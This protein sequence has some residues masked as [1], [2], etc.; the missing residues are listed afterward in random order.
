[1]IASEWNALQSPNNKVLGYNGVLNRDDEIG[2]PSPSAIGDMAAWYDATD[3]GSMVIDASAN[4]SLLSDVSGQSTENCL[5]LSGVIGN[6]A[7][8][9]DSAAL[10][11]TTSIDF[12]IRFAAVDWTPS[13]INLLLGKEK[14]GSK[15]SFVFYL[16]TTGSL[17]LGLSDDGTTTLPAVNSDDPVGFSDYNAGWL[18]VTWRASD[19][20][21]QF[22]TSDDSTSIPS[23]WT[24]LGA[25]KTI[26]IA[27]IYNSV[28]AVEIG[29][30]QDGSS[31]PTTGRF[32]RVNLA[33]SIDG[34]TVFDADFTAQSKLA[35]SFTESSANAATVTINST[36][37]A[38]PARIHGARDLYMGIAASQPKYLSYDGTNYAYLRGAGQSHFVSDANVD[39]TGDID[40]VSFIRYDSSTNPSAELI[41][42]IGGLSGEAI[43]RLSP[44]ESL[45]FSWFEGTTITAVVSSAHLVATGTDIYFRVKR[46]NDDGGIYKVYFYK[47]TDGSSWTLISS[48]NGAGVAAPT[49]STNVIKVGQGGFLGLVYK[50]E[51]WQGDSTAGGTLVADLNPADYTSGSTFV[52]SATGET[53]TL[54]GNTHIVTRTGVY[55]DSQPDYMKSAPFSLPQPENVYLV[56]EQLKW[57]TNPSIFEGGATNGIMKLGMKTSEPNIVLGNNSSPLV[58]DWLMH[59]HAVVYALFNSASSELR[60]NRNAAAVSDI[61]IANADRFTLAARPNGQRNANIFVSEI[62]IYDTVA[63]DTATQDRIIRYL[64]RKESI[65]V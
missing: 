6:Y 48:H 2:L 21:V 60:V 51:A 45:S 27:G 4:V 56:G 7:S 12:K 11:F 50:A 29:S 3:F 8:S 32:Y 38:L 33:G 52:S 37:I 1:M 57:G 63:H 20:R 23:V 16:D 36:A 13:A 53:W 24:Q 43:F 25:D 18:R 34:T 61:G 17:A 44:T 55:F 26:A 14:D 40:L 15:R 65:D 9:P 64:A 30:R 39:L 10:D 28:S 58:S 42:D 5:V 49:S 31:L 54:F 62:L 19:G 59:T 35:T 41:S 22:F 47:S 46:V